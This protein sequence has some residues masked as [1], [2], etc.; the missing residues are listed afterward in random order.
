MYHRPNLPD[1]FHPCLCGRPGGYRSNPMPLY[2]RAPMRDPVRYEGPACKEPP[3]CKEK[4]ICK[5]NP[6]PEK[7]PTQPPKVNPLIHEQNNC[8]SCNS[9]NQLPFILLILYLFRVF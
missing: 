1:Q 8:Y 2:N 5:S 6:M 4:P 7:A 9:G 3:I